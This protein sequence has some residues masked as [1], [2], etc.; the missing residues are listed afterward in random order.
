MSDPQEE[1][2]RLEA[3]STRWS[4]LRQ[5]HGGSATLAGQARNAL[6]LRYLPALR[7][8]IGAIVQNAADADDI[9]HD[10]VLRLLAGDFGGADPSRGRFRDLL[11]TALRNMVRN[12]WAKQK[13][14]Q[15]VALDVANLAAEHDS[16]DEQRWLAQWRQS[17]LD[18]AWKALQHEQQRRPGS[19]AYTLL[20]LRSDHPDDTSEQLAQRLSETTGQAIRADALR[21]KLRRARLQFADLLIA[22]V[23]NGLHDPSPEKIE[24]ELVALGLMDVL[25]DLLPPDWKQQEPLA[26]DDE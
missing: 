26:E 1:R 13:R 11:K 19:L 24:D 5:A 21:Q 9:T 2:S 14:Q 6:V 22:E 16:E 12:R 25:R 18:L 17:V 8:Y 23:A 7:R 4:L 15:T 3:I 20:R 10:V